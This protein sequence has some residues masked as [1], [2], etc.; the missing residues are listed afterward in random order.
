MTVP[1]ATIIPGPRFVMTPKA[2]SDANGLFM[3]GNTD[4]D[5]TRVG[6]YAIEFHMDQAW[7][8][9]IGILARSG[10]WIAGQDDIAMLGPWPFRAFY[11]NGAGVDGSMVS[12][13]SAVITGTSSIIV[14]GYGQTIGLGVSCSAGTCIMYYTPLFGQSVV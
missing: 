5:N 2:A 7:Q 13:T 9:S 12:D 14:P 6:A 8:G 10:Q 1:I 11:L 4:P 3:L